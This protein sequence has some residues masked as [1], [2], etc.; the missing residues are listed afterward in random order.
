LIVV[1]RRLVTFYISEQFARFLVVGGIALA[2]NWLSR[3]VFNWFVG[4]GWAIV[5][6]YMVGILVAFCL[7]KIYVFPF[8]QRPLGF[9]I[10]FF[11]V[12]NV[13]A[14]PFV[15]ITAYVFGEWLLSGYMT[16][17]W[18]LALGHGL[19][20]TLPVFANFALHKFITFRGS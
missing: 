15:L 5:F 2:T 1:L 6:A 8:S 17:S 11:T 12:V 7:N 4:Y 20:I 9:E 18:A 10:L 14:F 13:V 3:F 19:A 16:R